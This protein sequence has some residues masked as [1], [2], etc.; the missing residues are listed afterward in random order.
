MNGRVK[1][2]QMGGMM[3]MQ[4]AGGQAMMCPPGYMPFPPG[5]YPAM[6]YAQQTVGGTSSAQVVM[7]GQAQAG[8]NG[9]NTTA[10]TAAAA[11]G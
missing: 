11:G 7:P 1:D 5:S 3:V 8:G 10:T 9:E 4:G 2:I 6:Q